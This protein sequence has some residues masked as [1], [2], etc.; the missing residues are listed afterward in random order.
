ME[1]YELMALRDSIMRTSGT[2][3][4]NAMA[5]ALKEKGLPTMFANFAWHKL[6]PR[7]VRPPRAQVREKPV[8]AKANTIR[9][10]EVWVSVSK[11]ARVLGVE[12]NTI[13]RWCPAVGKNQIVLP[14]PGGMRRYTLQ[15]N[16]MGQ[17]NLSLLQHVRDTRRSMPGPGRRLGGVKAGELLG[18]A[19]RGGPD[20]SRATK[21]LSLL[22]GVQNPG[23]LNAVRRHLNRLILKRRRA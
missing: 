17:V 4:Q 8:G 11:A 13:A 10:A 5:Q 23:V 21:A 1:I 19:I 15:R 16:K 14:F 2:T 12:R 3:P 20:Y 9:F 22:E 7:E 18:A 6:T